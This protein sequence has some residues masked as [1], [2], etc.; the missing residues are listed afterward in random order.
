MFDPSVKLEIAIALRKRVIAVNFQ[1]LEHL[2][3]IKEEEEMTVI[4]VRLACLPLLVRFCTE[5]S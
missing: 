2:P 3:E 1:E 4:K 5:L